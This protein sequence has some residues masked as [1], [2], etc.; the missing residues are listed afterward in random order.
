MF[1]KKIL[2]RILPYIPFVI[3]GLLPSYFIVRYFL[4]DESFRSSLIFWIGTFFLGLIAKWEYSL[5]NKKNSIK[6]ISKE[7]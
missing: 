7:G 3:F 6:I 5:L 1:I 2:K 4:E